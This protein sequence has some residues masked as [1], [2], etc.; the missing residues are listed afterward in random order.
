M[1][2]LRNTTMTREWHPRAI[3][4]IS[5]RS[6]Q[7]L[8][9]CIS[10]ALYA[11]DLGNWSSANVHANPNWIYA[12]FVSVVS[13]SSCIAQWWLALPRAASAI[14]DSGIFLLWLVAV[15]M[16]GQVLSGNKDPEGGHSIRRIGAAVGIDA[17]NMALWFASAVEVCF[18][19][20]ARKQSKKQKPEMSEQSESF[21]SEDV[22]VSGE[23]TLDDGKTAEEQ[24]P[25]YERV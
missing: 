8:F 14:W 23:K 20:G 10:A 5:L 22:K 15:A 11:I 9:S 4:Q 12:E 24:P 17:L 1:G 25:P 16:F 21:T 6:A 7:L 13:V 3:A 18:C 19:C 2:V